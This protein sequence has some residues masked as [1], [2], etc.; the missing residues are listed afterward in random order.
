MFELNEKQT[1]QL[2][3]DLYKKT[4]KKELEFW[5]NAVKKWGKI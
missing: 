3:K 2:I 1:K 4:T 5:K